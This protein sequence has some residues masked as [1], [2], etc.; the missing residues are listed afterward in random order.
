MNDRP[1]NILYIDDEA[2]NLQSFTA[3]F[4]KDYN[5]FT[6]TSAK[7]AVAILQEKNIHVIFAD[8]R[9]PAMTGVQFFESIMEKHPDPIR[10][11]V[12]GYT[13]ITSAIDAINKGE[14][15]RFISKPWDHE[16]V[17]N[18]IAQAF[19]IYQTRFD[20]RQRNLELRKAYEE[21]D[22]FVYNASHDLRAPLMSILGIIQLSLVEENAVTQK[23]YLHLIKQSVHKLDSFIIHVIDYYKN[24]RGTPVITEISFGELIAEAVDSIRFLPGFEKIDIQ[25]SIDQSTPFYSDIF[26]L[27]TVFNNLLTNAVKFQDSGKTVHSIK[28]NVAVSNDTC[29]IEIA[30]NGIGIKEA[31]IGKVFEMFFRGIS[32][33]PGSGI[34]LY[35]VR[36]AVAKLGGDLSVSSVYGESTIFKIV[37]PSIN[38]LS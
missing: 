23:E 15:F 17:Q 3:S 36:E 1:I 37:L 16:Y 7:E 25:T 26:K 35:I 21:L 5:I 14:V 2:Q 24:A 4:R 11:L 33:N 18:A 8:Q 19:D 10:I 32:P 30:D 13:D 31:D 34:G 29:N 20:L 28:L 12:T 38:I 6:T 22:K 27:R 9:M